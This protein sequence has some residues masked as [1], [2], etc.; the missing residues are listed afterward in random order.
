MIQ[1][2]KFNTSVLISFLF[3]AST[4]AQH[5]SV[6]ARLDTV[7]RSGF[8]SI[9][10]TPQLSSYVETG[11]SDLR[12]TD[13]KGKI[14]PYLLRTAS[15]S[16]STQD[17]A[18]LPIVKNELADSGRTVLILQNIAQQKISNI[19]LLLR[20]AAVTRTA[21]ISGSDDLTQWFTID[22]DI[23]FQKTF[24]TDSDRYIQTI[25]F[26][27]S[28]YKY[29]KIAI[30]NRKNNPLNIIEAGIYTNVVS[31][32]AQSYINNP[33]PAFY[34]TD[35]SDN[36]SYLHI[37]QHAPYHI[38]RMRLSIKA[39]R[40]FKRDIDV[41]TS[42]GISS[43]ELISGKE[44]FFELPS[45]NDTGFLIKI[46]NG[47]NPAVQVESVLTQQE[48][49]QMV[50]YLEGDKN[51]SLLMHDPAAQKPVYDLKQFQD[52]IGYTIPALRLTRFEQVNAAQS[53]Q[54]GI[55]KKWIWPVIIIMLAV[56]AFFT[57][58]LTREVGKR[59]PGNS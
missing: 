22:E 20:N 29:L 53:G 52:S 43:F 32:A 44:Q 33:A 49:L 45:F 58:R 17:Y 48:N 10:V 42:N 14:V 18:K 21:T 28:S 31:A 24:A 7:T 51:Y 37:T 55:S 36:N 3:C 13:D 19:A 8:Y 40:F 54:A 41:I 26:P 39:P 27:A 4:A 30:D 57:V 9:A 16:F 56:L 15:P 46:Y 38:E 2:K 23:Y 34:Q 1:T 12:I 25:Q 6:K 50:A 11:F 5:F 59:N 35:S 47:D